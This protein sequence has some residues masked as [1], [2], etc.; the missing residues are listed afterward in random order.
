MLLVTRPG[1]NT[2]VSH[3]ITNSRPAVS[4]PCQHQKVAK[5][6]VVLIYPVRMR[7]TITTRG[8]HAAE[9]VAMP[10]GY[11]FADRWLNSF[12]YH[13]SLG[14]WPFAVAGLMATVLAFVTVGSQAMKVV[15][16]RPGVTPRSE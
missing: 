5:V 4:S 16:T 3:R 10:I 12:A 7:T 6:K 8:H 15:V 14:L 2:K 11:Y 9:I 13:V 1:E